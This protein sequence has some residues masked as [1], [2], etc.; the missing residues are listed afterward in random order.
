MGTSK[1]TTHHTPNM[2]ENIQQTQTCNSMKLEYMQILYKTYFS[3][4]T[5]LTHSDGHE[6]GFHDDH[7]RDIDDTD[8][9]DDDDYAYDDDDYDDDENH[10]EHEQ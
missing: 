6:E 3:T 7:Y 4:Y 8:D 10:D 1:N 5:R 2:S 9:V